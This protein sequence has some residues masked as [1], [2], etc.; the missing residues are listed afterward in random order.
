MGKFKIETFFEFFVTITVAIFTLFQIH[1][2]F[3]KDYQTWIF[4]LGCALF[5]TLIIY[6]THLR[7]ERRRDVNR[8]IKKELQVEKNNISRFIDE[9]DSQ[10]NPYKLLFFKWRLIHENE[11]F[12]DVAGGKFSAPI[13]PMYSY[14][15]TIFSGMIDMLRDGDNYYSISTFAFWKND[16]IFEKDP[17][18]AKKEDFMKKNIDCIKK[19]TKSNICR[20]IIF[21]AALL[22]PL[23]NDPKREWLKQLVQGFSE[24]I[25]I[26][27]EGQRKR[28][29]V[30][31]YASDNYQGDI[32]HKCA[33]FAYIQSGNN[34]LLKAVPNNLEDE[35]QTMP[36]IE[37]EYGDKTNQNDFVILKDMYSDLK[38]QGEA[39]YI[40]HEIDK[41]RNLLNI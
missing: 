20:I 31:F 1:D 18:L 39:R 34:F 7:D 24:K 38:K 6:F 5:T 37:F 40:L 32:K 15:R 41:M 21:D 4:L 29:P 22:N 35:K 36:T 10:D 17:Y 25:L 12:K 19:N 8:Q 3:S 27:D 23:S 14:M 13:L 16:E 2:Y 33:P 28:L 9:A 30:H 11:K 26:L